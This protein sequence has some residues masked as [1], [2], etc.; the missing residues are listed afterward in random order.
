MGDDPLIKAGT[1]S[2]VFDGQ[3]FSVG[4]K[5]HLATRAAAMTN[6]AF[7]TRR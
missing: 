3:F 4:F 6:G 1:A 7:C 2:G 5:T